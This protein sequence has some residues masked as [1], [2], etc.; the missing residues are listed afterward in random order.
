MNN[1]SIL[2][3]LLFPFVAVSFLL[4]L[5]ISIVVALVWNTVS[6]VFGIVLIFLHLAIEWGYLEID[7]DWNDVWDLL[8]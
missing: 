6:L 1:K 4:R 3:V 7:W 5:L 2:T 8:G